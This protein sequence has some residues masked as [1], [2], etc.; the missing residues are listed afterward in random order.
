MATSLEHTIPRPSLISS[1]NN[2]DKSLDTYRNEKILLVGDFKAQ[3]TDHCLSSSLYQHELSSIV[4]ES[5]CFKNVS[6]P[7][8]IHLLLPNSALS[9]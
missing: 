6:N 2:L 4:K 9:F 8:C 3:T 1:I 5:T 7:S